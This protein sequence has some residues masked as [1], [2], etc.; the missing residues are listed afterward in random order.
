M[1]E[2]ERNGVGDDNYDEQGD[3]FPAGSHQHI[4]A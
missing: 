3:A 2:K 1:W 4:G